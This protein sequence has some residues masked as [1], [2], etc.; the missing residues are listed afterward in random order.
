MPTHPV[1]P[2]AHY[3]PTDLYEICRRH[4]LAL[5]AEEKAVANTTRVMV[6]VILSE[7]KADAGMLTLLIDPVLQIMKKKPEAENDIFWVAEINDVT[8]VA[9]LHPWCPE[10]VLI[11]ACL[12]P[13]GSIRK[14]AALNPKCPE[15]S[16]IMAA[17]LG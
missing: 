1:K 16:Q 6:R 3:T 8:T 7:N 10:S 11:A 17:L 5:H 14:Y 12:S 4:G 9:L 2:L 13:S 15:D